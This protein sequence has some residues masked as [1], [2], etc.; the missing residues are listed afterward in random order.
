MKFGSVR[1]QGTCEFA[2]LIEIFHLPSVS[3]IPVHIRY[4]G[5]GN[6]IISDYPLVMDS[7]GYGY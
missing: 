6:E 7:F 4:M 3:D 2:S 1:Y 5:Y